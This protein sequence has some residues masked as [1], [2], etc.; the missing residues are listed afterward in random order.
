[1]CL[2]PMAQGVAP[3]KC[4]HA[5]C[6]GCTRRLGESRSTPCVLC[7][8]QRAAYWQATAACQRCGSAMLA[9]DGLWDGR[10][11]MRC[12]S[13]LGRV[14]RFRATTMVRSD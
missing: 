10:W 11:C 6:L 1:M 9:L 12:H 13:R 14:R 3:V 2:E 4:G 5:V 8:D 7:R